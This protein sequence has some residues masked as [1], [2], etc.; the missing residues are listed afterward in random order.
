MSPPLAHI[1][2]PSSSPLHLTTR[3]W[4]CC[5]LSFTRE[6]SG[7]DTQKKIE[8]SIEQAAVCRPLEIN[9]RFYAGS[10]FSKLKRWCD[11][12]DVSEALR[13][14]KK[15]SVS[16][17]VTA[18]R[19]G[20]CAEDVAWRVTK[21]IQ[22]QRNYLTLCDTSGYLRIFYPSAQTGS[23]ADVTSKAFCLHSSTHVW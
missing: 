5:C 1:S 19:V 22:Q 16:Y 10:F 23:R 13:Q 17:I 2:L 12:D 14:E 20:S 15:T 18:T 3:W 9:S 11:N 6:R 21:C 4:W 7:R 8:I